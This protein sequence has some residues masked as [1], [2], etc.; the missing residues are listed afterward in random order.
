MVYLNAFGQPMLIIHGLKAASELLHRRA[1]IYSSRPRLI[2]AHEILSGGLFTS[3]LPYGEV[4]VWSFSRETGLNRLVC[5]W[6][7][8]RRAA[9]EGLSKTAIRDYH[10][11]L[12]KEAVILASALLENPSDLEQHFQ[13][14]AASATLSIMYDYPTLD[15]EEDE[16]LK[17][18]RNYIDR[19]SAASAPGAYLVEAMP[20]MLHIPE[21]YVLSLLLSGRD[22]LARSDSIA[23]DS[24]SG[25]M[26]EG[27]SSSNTMLCIR[28]S[29]ME[30]DTKW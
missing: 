17:G 8:N 19:M 1:H 22:F 20:W 24:Q 26:K 9:R 25:S 3:F 15:T 28:D 18:I 21:T 12:R 7:R 27:D 6:R 5:R 2:M 30:F 11:I 13:R 10:P 29:S 23:S 4:C 14:V 16:N